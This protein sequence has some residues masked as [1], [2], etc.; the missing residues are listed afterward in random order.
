[1][2]VT[3]GICKWYEPDFGMWCANG[4]TRDGSTGKCLSTAER[5]ETTRRDS[6]CSAWEAAIPGAGP[7]KDR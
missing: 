5:R 6:R 4:W 7:G 2:N 1:M 3:C